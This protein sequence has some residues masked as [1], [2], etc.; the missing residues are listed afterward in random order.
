MYVYI[1][2]VGKVILHV[3]G[4]GGMI[5]LEVCTVDGDKGEPRPNPALELPEADEASPA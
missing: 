2:A 5:N 3:G 4:W 1:Y